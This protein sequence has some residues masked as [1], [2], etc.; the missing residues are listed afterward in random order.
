MV[1]IIMAETPVSL[2]GGTFKVAIQPS[3]VWRILFAL[4]AT[5][6]L[7][8][9]T[10]KLWEFVAQFSTYKSD[11]SKILLLFQVKVLA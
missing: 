7:P 11:S 6:F 5:A 10:P 9:C 2:L 8:E 4:I 3:I 1:I